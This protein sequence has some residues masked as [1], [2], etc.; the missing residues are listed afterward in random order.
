MGIFVNIII[1]YLPDETFNIRQ[2]ISLK[3]SFMKN[4]N[5]ELCFYKYF[6]PIISTQSLVRLFKVVFQNCF[7]LPLYTRTT[8]S[9]QNTLKVLHIII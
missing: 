6:E 8:A 7:L 4:N 1:A 9:L 5:T 2:E 3:V